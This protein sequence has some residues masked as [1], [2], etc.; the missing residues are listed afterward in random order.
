MNRRHGRDVQP[1]RRIRQILGTLS[2]IG[3]TSVNLGANALTLNGS[4]NGTFGG[5]IG[6]TGSVTFAG[7]G[8]QTLTGANTGRHDDQRRQHAGARRGRQSR[9]G[10]RGE[11]R[12]HGCDVQPER[13]IGSQTLGTL[14]GGAGTN[15]NLGANGLTLNG[16]AT[17][18]SAARSAAPA[19]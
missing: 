8:T 19:A 3:G 13:R 2:G 9:V 14:S 17:T 1:E 11:S 5:V 16:V 15:V 12:R 4:T 6:G 10:Q 18:R 7:T